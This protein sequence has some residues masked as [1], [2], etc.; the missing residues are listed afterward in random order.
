MKK[1][2]SLLFL[3]ISIPLFCCSQTRTQIESDSLAKY[4]FEQIANTYEAIRHTNLEAAKIYLNALH[5]KANTKK[6]KITVFLKMCHHEIFHGTKEKAFSYLESAYDLA[7]N[8]ESIELGYVYEKKGYYYYTEQNYDEALRYYVKALA[9]AEE[10]Q[11]Q[12]LFIKVEHKIGALHY[13]LGALDKA[14]STFNQLLKKVE[15]DAI[16]YNTRIS[17]LS[18]LANTYLRKYSHYNEQ[19]K[20]LDSFSFFTEKGLQYAI[21]ENDQKKTAYFE[22]LSGI[23]F[24]IKEDYTTALTY[25]NNS[26]KTNKTL[27]IKR[28]LQDIYFYKGKTFL[29]LQQADSAIFY[30]K[31]SEPFFEGASKKLKHPSSYALLSECYELKGDLKKAIQYAKLANEYIEQ[32]YSDNE[33]TKASIDQEYTLPKLQKRIYKLEEALD[34][35]SRKKTGWYIFSLLLIVSLVVGYLVFRKR[36]Q[37]NKVAFQ[38]LL[39]ETK[40][41][42]SHVTKK[43]I[44]EAQTQQILDALVKF[45]KDHLFLEQNCTLPFLAK[46]LNTNTAYLSNIINMYKNESY[47]TYLKKLR[48]QYSIQRLK[49]DTRFRAYTIESIAKECGFK[50]AKPF[51]RAFKKVTNIYPSTF[52]KNLNKIEH[53][54]T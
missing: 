37:K 51:S 29:R 28:T 35:T 8:E 53:Q 32:R 9:V 5:T 38:K 6:E 36:E 39:E 11:D 2:I 50:T 7:K 41:S 4:S 49:D 31:K 19:K 33:K 16:P 25:F 26:L 40:E 24:F 44:P 45:E 54:N 46:K 12:N 43:V 22:H 15:I 18:S 30:I 52:I 13:T 14:L 3:Y 1:A 21:Q 42:T 10:K 34:T 23:S 20:L 47:T 48:V 27:N 17:I